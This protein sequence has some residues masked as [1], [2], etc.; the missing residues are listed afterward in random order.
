MCLIINSSTGFD[1]V[2]KELTAE[3]YDRN[4]DGFGYM[5]QDDGQLV[6][7]KEVYTHHAPIHA[8]MQDLPDDRP[9]SVH[10]RFATSGDIVSNT[11]HPFPVIDQDGYTVWLMHNGIMNHWEPPKGDKTG[12]SDTLRFIAN[13]L[14]PRLHAVPKMWLNP[15]FIK[16]VEKHIGDTNKLVMFD[17]EGNTATFNEGAG[18]KWEDYWMSNTYAWPSTRY[19]YGDKYDNV[20]SGHWSAASGKFSWGD[21]L[22]DDEVKS[23][24]DNWYNVK[25]DPIDISSDGVPMTKE[26]DYLDEGVLALDEIED[27]VYA[28]PDRAAK[29]I[30]RNQG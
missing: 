8:M 30:Y 2:T 18:V 5:Y 3:I 27:F 28:N 16:V 19:M 13:F 10:F 7:H 25:S 12:M 4:S 24:W 23:Y 9:V 11:A 6:V 20:Y 21:T 29:W 1:K 17:N 15:N 14:T 22:E 26:E